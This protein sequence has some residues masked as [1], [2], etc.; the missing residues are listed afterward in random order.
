MFNKIVIANRGE[1]AVRI[2]NACQAMGIAT[3]ALYTDADSTWLARQRAD[4]A[5]NMGTGPAAES[6]INFDKV[7]DAAKH[8]GADAIH[9][10]YGF[11]AE[12][13][14]FARRCEQEGI[15]FIGPSADVI[16][17]MGNKA[18]AKALVDTL[19]I[20]TIPGVND[21]ELTAEQLIEA[22]NTMGYPVMLKAV[23]GGGGMGI[24]IVESADQ[25]T[26]ALASVQQ[27]AGSA[28]GD[29]RVLLEKYFP[30]VRHIE[31]Q[32]LADQ[33]GNAVHCYERECSV[34]RRRQKVVEEA[35]SM[36][37]SE[38]L[39]QQLCEASL[40]I[41]KAVGYHSV[42]TVE[43]VVVDEPNS[44]DFYFLEMNTRLQVEHGVTEAVT[45][46]DLVQQ[47][48]AVAEGLPLSV[49]Q[50]DIVLRGHA[51]EARLCAEQPANNFQPMTG[52][53]E[54]WSVPSNDHLRVDTGIQ[55][56]TDISVFYD[57]LIAKVI[58]M[59][60]NREQALRTLSYGLQRTTVLGVETNQPFILN[61]LNDTPFINSLANTTYIE[62]HEADLLKPLSQAVMN[63]LTVVGVTGLAL[64]DTKHLQQGQGGAFSRFYSL[65][66]EGQEV[67]AELQCSSPNHYTV[68]IAAQ[69]NDI[70]VKQ[71]SAATPELSLSINGVEKHYLITLNQQ[72]LSIHIPALGNFIITRPSRLSETASADSDHTYTA[73]MAGQVVA[74]LAQ[75][76]ATIT[77]GDKLLVIE[78]MKMEHSIVATRAGEVESVLV[79]VG[80]AVAAGTVLLTLQE[81]GA[82]A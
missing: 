29:D 32:V 23:S 39:R 28:F 16:D 67:T 75:R 35:P 43:F 53:I 20:P 49:Q 74:V 9:P 34:Q 17:L 61:I 42:G 1:I 50:S 3:V 66:I 57:S 40:K 8:T 45:G 7:I 62:N 55:S 15:V 58:G 33:H 12:N 47:Q 48:I 41:L 68:V 51:I 31:V 38:S 81:E 46:L 72:Q 24:R 10:G 69:R 18:Q 65:F 52:T 27:E 73:S 13:A 36:F 77:A 76:G 79:E 80:N 71:Q 2:I 63:E 21:T 78:S 54:H 82:V 25:I 22:A 30:A 37:V 60:S 6:Y 5:V 26:D 19:F 56:G 14:A 64:D 11:L 4:E 70:V 59:G 44:E